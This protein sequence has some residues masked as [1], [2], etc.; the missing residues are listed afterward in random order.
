MQPGNRKEAGGEGVPRCEDPSSYHNRGPR[1]GREGP[2]SEKEV[3]LTPR[4]SSERKSGPSSRPSCR[5]GGARGAKGED[6]VG[7]TQRKTL[8]PASEAP[9]TPAPCPPPPPHAGGSAQLKNTHHHGCSEVRVSAGAH[10]TAAQRELA[11]E[12]GGGALKQ[13]LPSRAQGA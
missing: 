12:G 3:E 10:R 13:P 7:E 6:G 2:A 8:M 4:S 9:A 5:V 11:T 1:Q